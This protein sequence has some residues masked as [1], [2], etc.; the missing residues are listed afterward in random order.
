MPTQGP[1]ASPVVTNQ[2]LPLHLESCQLILGIEKIVTHFIFGTGGL[3]EKPG[4][5]AYGNCFPR[6]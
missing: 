1:T 2:L 6:H 5:E 3:E 4:R